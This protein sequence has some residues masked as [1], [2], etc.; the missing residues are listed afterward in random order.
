MATRGGSAS[1]HEGPGRP[2]ARGRAAGETRRTRVPRARATRARRLSLD[3]RSGT[4]CADLGRDGRTRGEEREAEGGGGRGGAGGAATLSSHLPKALQRTLAPRLPSSTAPARRPRGRGICS[5]SAPAATA[6]RT[7]LSAG[8][9]PLRPR[10]PERR[11]PRPPPLSAPARSAPRNSRPAHFKGPPGTAKRAVRLPPLPRAHQGSAPSLRTQTSRAPRQG[12]GPGPRIGSP[13]RP[14]APPR[15]GPG[16][17]EHGGVARPGR[18]CA[19]PDGE[20]GG[21]GAPRRPSFCGRSEWASPPPRPPSAPLAPA[22]PGFRHGPRFQQPLRAP[23]VLRAL[24]TK[25]A[26]WI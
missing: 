1:P 13:P 6:T 19:E 8:P 7:S 4:L 15:A 18:E 10:P 17:G 5:R 25:T 24:P 14:R 20:G 2:G 22:R 21:R 9:L 16:V 11:A 26:P 12:L 3:R 23:N